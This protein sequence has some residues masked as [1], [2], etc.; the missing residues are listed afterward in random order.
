M[1]KKSDR[2]AASLF[3]VKVALDVNF[4]RMQLVSQN[5]H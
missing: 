3:M 5:E 1:Q 2:L 4:A